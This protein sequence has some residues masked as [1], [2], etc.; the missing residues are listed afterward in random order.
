MPQD[1][2]SVLNNGLL[3]L[4][5]PANLPFFFTKIL[6]A[7]PANATAINNMEINTIV[8]IKF[9][10]VKREYLLKKEGTAC[11]KSIS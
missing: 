7:I 9:T 3:L 1:P 8:I 6:M 10:K 2:P 11:Y 5:V 4:H